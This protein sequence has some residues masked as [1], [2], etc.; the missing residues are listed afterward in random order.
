M[1]RLGRSAI[2]WRWISARTLAALASRT[3]S[4]TPLAAPSALGSRH[5]VIERIERLLDAHPRRLRPSLSALGAVLAFIAIAAFVL[6][7]ISPVFAYASQSTTTAEL[8]GTVQIAGACAAPNRPIQLSASMGF[9]MSGAPRWYPAEDAAKIVA[10]FTSANVAV[11]DLT[12]DASGT[13][14]VAIVSAPSY[15]GMPGFVTNV[16]ARDKYEPGLRNCVPVT[17]TIRTGLRIGKPQGDS[18]SIV[19]PSYPDGWSSQHPAACKVPN[20]LHTGVPAFPSSLDGLSVTAKANVSAR[21]TVDASGA[22]TNAAIVS[23]SGQTA[24]DDAL[25]QSGEVRRIH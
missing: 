6:Q 14:R 18:M 21:V 5:A 10:R 7:S 1:R 13:P 16:F 3:R 25:L 2:R 8:A 12:V 22:V 17:S 9:R 24:F 19:A 20:V 11:V 15:A 4:R 23:P